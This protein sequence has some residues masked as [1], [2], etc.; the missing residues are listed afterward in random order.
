MLG[1]VGVL[2]TAEDKR[3]NFEDKQIHH[4]EING[5]EQIEVSYCNFNENLCEMLKYKFDS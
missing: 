3:L 5:L 1:F 4:L 2:T